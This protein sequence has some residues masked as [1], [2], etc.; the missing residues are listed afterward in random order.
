VQAQDRHVGGVDSLDTNRIG[1]VDQAAY[2]PG[3][4]LLHAVHAARALRAAREVLRKER[5]K[6]RRI[7]TMSY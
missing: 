4:E 6:I 1:L 5:E 3:Q 7:F 2:D